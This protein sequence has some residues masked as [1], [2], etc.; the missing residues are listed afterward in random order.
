M[1]VNVLS[2]EDSRTL[3]T[4]LED[5]LPFLH[6]YFLSLMSVLSCVDFCSATLQA[7]EVLKELAALA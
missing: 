4:L 6:R 2:S 7:A 1:F 3:F 5:L